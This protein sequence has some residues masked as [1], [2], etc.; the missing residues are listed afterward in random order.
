MTESSPPTWAAGPFNCARTLGRLEQPVAYLGRLR[1]TA[2]ARSC[3]SS[4]ART[5]EPRLVVETDDPTTLALAEVD[6]QGAATYRFYHEG[7]SVPGLTPE[8]ALRVL[9][10]RVDMVHVGTL[11]LVFE[12]TADALE[13]VVEQ[14]SGGRS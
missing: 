3:A 9:P 14:V 13:A 4:C 2:S 12:P 1:T 7:T 8:H 11:G 10:E 5:G 6:E